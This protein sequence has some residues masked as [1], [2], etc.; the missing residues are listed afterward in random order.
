[1]SEQPP[2]EPYEIPGTV[3]AWEPE[4]LPPHGLTAELAA[5]LIPKQVG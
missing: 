1:V 4:T 5:P 2:E 3:P